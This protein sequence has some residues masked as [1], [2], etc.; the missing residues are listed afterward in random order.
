MAT[1]A[2]GSMPSDSRSSN[3]Y[4]G[5]TKVLFGLTTSELI[6]FTVLAAG[7]TFPGVFKWCFSVASYLG[8]LFSSGI[9][10]FTL[11]LATV[12]MI[13]YAIYKI[14]IF[15]NIKRELITDVSVI[16]IANNQ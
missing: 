16:N 12:G 13:G 7:L 5:S 6:F 1:R 15:F 10:G 4:Q 11:A 3:K 2:G 9:M 8:S 14:Y